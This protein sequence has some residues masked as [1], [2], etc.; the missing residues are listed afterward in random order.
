MG[1]YGCV[2]VCVPKEGLISAAPTSLHYHLLII[3]Q[4]HLV[5]L[6]QVQHGDGAQFGGNTTG[7][8]DAGVDRVD[9]GLHNGM[10]GGVEVVGQRKGAV[11][12]AV[13]GLV[14]WWGHNPV[15]PAH[16]TEVHIERVAPAVL[17]LLPGP[18]WVMLGA[19]LGPPAS[20][21]GMSP[22]IMAK[23]DQEGPELGPIPT[24]LR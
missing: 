14:A 15:V 12:V 22:A 16:I 21:Q 3:F 8:G 18:L 19:T 4:N 7:F 10:D 6:I 9:E 17:I 24:P 23:G 5:I 1:V 20:G 11:P 2:C 13:E